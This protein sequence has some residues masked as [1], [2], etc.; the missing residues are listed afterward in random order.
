MAWC[1]A[2]CR[3]GVN[4]GATWGLTILILWKHQQIAMLEKDRD[5][6]DDQDTVY[7]SYT[8]TSNH[9]LL[10]IPYPFSSQLISISETF[11][12][13]VI[14]TFINPSVFQSLTIHEP[15][16]D[17]SFTIHPPFLYPSFSTNFSPY[18]QPPPR[19]SLGLPHASPQCRGL[20]LPAGLAELSGGVMRSVS[21]LR[22]CRA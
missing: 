14:T 16:I 12:Y 13:P 10:A 2:V 20:D 18:I 1:A 7:G 19:P 17:H 21:R 11:H 22:I 5:D 9:S 4:R 3:V 8:W 6:Q 15:F